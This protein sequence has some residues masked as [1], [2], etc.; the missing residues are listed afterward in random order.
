MPARTQKTATQSSGFT[1]IELL[2]VIAVIGILSSIGLVSLQGTR[3]KARDAK[4]KHDLRLLTTALMLYHD[5]VGIYPNN[6]EVQ[7]TATSV[8]QPANGWTAAT[9]QAYLPNL[10]NPPDGGN[11]DQTTYFYSRDF[12]TKQFF[13]VTTKME[14][15][16]TPWYYLTYLGATGYQTFAR[17]NCT[18]TQG[19][20][21]VEN[22]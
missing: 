3:E 22:P 14:S 6:G 13:L 1:L 7:H 2:I 20:P 12:G 16:G 21:E 8:G 18:S 5:D 17:P 15:Q 19:C 10:P 4:R 11:V 9:L